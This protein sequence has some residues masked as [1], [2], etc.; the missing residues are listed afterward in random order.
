VSRLGSQLASY[1]Q[2]PVLNQLQAV[3]GRLA[4]NVQNASGS[5][6]VVPTVGGN[7]MKMAATVY[8]DVTAWTGI[9]RANGLSD[10]VVQGVQTLT[11][12]AVADNSG[13]LI[14]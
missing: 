11:V 2:L 13:G 5:G 1:T 10:P 14:G 9:A 8:S 12:P 4:I 7:L 3:T 6:H